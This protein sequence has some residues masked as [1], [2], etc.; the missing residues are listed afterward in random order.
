MTLSTGKQSFARGVWL[1]ET[2][3]ESLLGDAP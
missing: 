1:A 3:T 2:A